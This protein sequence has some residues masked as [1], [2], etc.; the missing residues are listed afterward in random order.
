VQNN[1]DNVLQE[2]YASSYTPFSSLSYLATNP[3]QYAKKINKNKNNIYN[4][5]LLNENDEP[6]N[7]NGCNMSL[8]ILLFKKQD[9]SLLKEYIKYQLSK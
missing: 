2:I 1:D 4:F 9:K 6:I 7:L 8:T 5:Y 3:Y